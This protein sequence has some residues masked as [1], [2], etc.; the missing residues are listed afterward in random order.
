[1]S[2]SIDPDQLVPLRTAHLVMF[3]FL[4]QY[5]ERTGRPEEIAAA[6]LGAM[7]PLDD[8]SP[9]DAATISDWLEAAQ[10]VLGSK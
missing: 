2:N 5:W 8:G 7:R 10:R 9:A 4:N 1:M 3:E 6:L